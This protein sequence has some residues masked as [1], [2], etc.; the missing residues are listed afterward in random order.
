MSFLKGRTS[1]VGMDSECWAASLDAVG[2]GRVTCPTALD[3][4]EDGSVM[5]EA[6]TVYT[7]S[8]RY[9]VRPLEKDYPT[10]ASYTVAAM[11]FSNEKRRVRYVAVGR[12]TPNR[13]ADLVRAIPHVALA[14]SPHLMGYPMYPYRAPGKTV[15]VIAFRASDVYAFFAACWP[16]DN[17]GGLPRWVP[18]ASKYLF[19]FSTLAVKELEH[20]V[21][22]EP[23]PGY[24]APGFYLP[25][26][27]DI[28]APPPDLGPMKYADLHQQSSPTD[29][30]G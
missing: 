9:A 19:G 14:V 24:V 20:T 28:I 7:Y 8:G 1:L 12:I 11:N 22:G 2:E 21:Y 3:P 30:D 4:H 13:R 27:G 15:E 10:H 18:F 23:I 26:G 25:A 6:P 17:R 29:V 5:P 16:G